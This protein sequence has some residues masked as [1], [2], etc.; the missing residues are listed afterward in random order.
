MFSAYYHDQISQKAKEDEIAKMKHLKSL[1]AHIKIRDKLAVSNKKRVEKR[2][3]EMSADP[4]PINRHEISTKFPDFKG[5]SFIRS[6]PKDTKER[7]K[8]AEIENTWL[9]TVPLLPSPHNFRQR[10]K[11][12][13]INSY[14]KYRPKDRYERVIDTWNNQSNT[15]EHSWEVKPIK[16]NEVSPVFPNTLKKS[17]YKTLESVAMGFYKKQK[18]SSLPRVNALNTNEEIEGIDAAKTDRKLTEIAREVM[19]KCKLKPLKEELRSMYTRR[20]SK[21]NQDNLVLV[22]KTLY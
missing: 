5:E 1:S 13:E 19:E 20:S 11:D 10:F 3:M 12:K 2:V 14:M 15:L 4:V 6:K 22:R 16:K 18:S 21:V 17:Y 9:D 7:I 8:D